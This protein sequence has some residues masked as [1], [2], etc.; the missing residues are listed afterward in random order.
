MVCEHEIKVRMH[1]LKANVPLIAG[2][3]QPSQPVL[4]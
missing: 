2:V 3:I 1:L 4:K